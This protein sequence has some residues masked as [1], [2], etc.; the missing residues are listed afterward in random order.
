[1]RK[2]GKFWHLALGIVLLIGLL[3]ASPAAVFAQTPDPARATSVGE[4]T[5]HAKP[6]AWEFG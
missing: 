1:M 6:G 5:G 3:S 4:P 2:S